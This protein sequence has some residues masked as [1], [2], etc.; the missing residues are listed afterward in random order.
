[1][2][3]E[4]IDLS[5]PVVGNA[6]DLLPMLRD[7]VESQIQGLTKS[8]AVD[9]PTGSGRESVPLRFAAIRS[10]NS[11]YR[12]EVEVAHRKSDDPRPKLPNIFD[13]RQRKIGRT[14]AFN[15]AMLIPTG[16]NCTI[17]GHAGD[18]TPTA[19]LLATV[20]DNLILHPNVVNAS[21]IN[22][23]PANALYVEG[24][25]I[26][27]LMMGTLAL[28]RVRQNRILT[29]T[30]PREDGPWALDHV[31]NTASA[32]RATLG[33]DC[34]RVV[35]LEKPIHMK[36]AVTGSG[37]ATGDV[38]GLA[39]L[40]DVLDHY[41][42]QYDAVALA[43]KITPGADSVAL[44]HQYFSEGGVN[45]WGG[46]EAALTHAVS[47]LYNVPSAHAPT[48]SDLALRTQCF[49]R[50]EPRKAAE[51]ISVAY[52]FCVMKGLHQ[53]PRIV[54][55][56]DGSYDPSLIGAEDVS[57]LVIPDGTLGLPVFAAVA[58]G[59]PVIAVRGNTNLMANDLT[60]LP[61]AAG[62]LQF[63][64]NYFEA[65]GL[66]QAMK[67][68]ITRSTVERPMNTTWVEHFRSGMSGTNATTEATVS[69]AH[70][71]NGPAAAETVSA[72]S[73]AFRATG[74]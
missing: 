39:G 28:Q 34:D 50:V 41:K 18:A 43:T 13:Y 62:Q 40:F 16:V 44:H 31:V 11:S 45:P 71:S 64:D 54:P 74:V 17:G 37:R 23:M 3:I 47:S 58:Q 15:A 67:H 48:M 51:I 19:R 61:W 12:C 33:A 38:S 69:P 6:A 56:H 25:L 21:D 26:T 30:E 60:A 66:M 53:A 73:A 52:F 27:R 55:N 14:S 29:I 70:S 59:I 65:V 4:S 63:C 57:C 46:V 2:E 20:C 36:M 1:M 42:G 68:G 5:V 22:E 8:S 35:V 24:S 7:V 72:D 32:A 49:G 10:E 9:A